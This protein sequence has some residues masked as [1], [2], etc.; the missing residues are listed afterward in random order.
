MIY[1][2]SRNLRS[3]REQVIHKASVEK[4][5][6][7]IVHEPLIIGPPNS[8]RHA[9]MYLPLDNRGINHVSAIMHSRIFKESHHARLWIN[10]DDGS[11]DPAGKTAMRRA[12]KPAG[13]KAR[14]PALWWQSWSRARTSQLHRH[15]LPSIFTVG[16]A[17]CVSGE[18]Q[19]AQCQRTL[20]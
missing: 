14:S 2:D 3:R 16:K 17:R 6:F 4:L 13:F 20:G 1:Y 7:F 12:I 11:V 19:L 18:R 10:L 8:L 9:T 15:E 5:T